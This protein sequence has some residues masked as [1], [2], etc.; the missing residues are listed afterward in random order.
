[1]RNLLMVI[2]SG[3]IFIMS[4]WSQEPQPT[5]DCDIN[6]DGFVDAADLFLLMKYWHT[7]EPVVSTP[8]ETPVIQITPTPTEPT[9]TPTET[10]P[11]KPTTT[12]TNTST[13]TVKPTSTPLENPFA[14]SWS[15]HI[16]GDDTGSGQINIDNKG[17]MSGSVTGYYDTSIVS[18]TVSETG[19]A[20]FDL[21][22]SGDIIGGGSGAFGSNS[23]SGSWYTYDGN[24]G[25]WTATKI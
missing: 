9:L 15:I 8:T 22:Q 17:N 6:N 23:G 25:T 5:P 16:Y 24:D 10:M 20:V 11:P 1:M 12:P 13:P 14:G 18:G 2:L 7:G 19:N 3:S 21:R 4:A